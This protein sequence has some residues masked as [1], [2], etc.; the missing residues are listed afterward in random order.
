VIREDLGT[1]ILVEAAAG[2]GKTQSLVDRMVALIVAGR[3]TVDRLSAVTFTIR[4][5]AQLK[6]RFQNALERSLRVEREAGRKQALSA[7]LRGIDGCFVGTI[8]AFCAR[9]L[10]ERPVEAGVDPG[11]EEMDE[12]EDGVARAEAWA[13]FVESLYFGDDPRLARLLDLGIELEDLREGFGE[14]CENSDVVIRAGAPARAPDFSEALRAI[15]R[16]LERVEPSLPPEA[17]AGGWSSFQDGVRRARRLRDLMDPA[18]PADFAAVARVFRP[19]EVVNG[20]GPR[21]AELERLR[22]D[23]VKPALAAWAEHVYPTVLSLLLSAREDYERWRRREGRLNFQDLLLFARDLLRDRPDVRAAL[24]SRFTPILVDEFQDTDPIQAEI[25]FYLTGSDAEERD[26]R[27][28]SPEPGSLFVA[29]DPKQSIYRFR[30]ADIETYE[31]V[32]RRVEECGGR[33]VRL[34][35]NFRSSPAICNWVNGVFGRPEFFPSEPTSRQAS[36][37]PIEPTRG[38]TGPEPAILRLETNGARGMDAIADA[39]AERI[40][41][42]IAGSVGSEPRRPGDFL[43]LFRRRKYMNDYARALERRGIPYE[44]GGGDAFKESDDLAMLLP[45][46]QALAEP[47]DPV[48]LLATLRGPLFGIDDTALYRFAR[49]GGRFDFRLPPPAGTDPGIATALRLFR[50][51]S[52]LV[53]A[54]PPA[55]AIGR[56]LERL[57]APAL[58]ATRELGESRA[59]NLLKALAAARSLSA[60]GLDF[61]KVVAELDRLRS[62]RLIEQMS[63]EPGRSDAVRLLTLHGAKGLEGR[64][65]FLADPARSNFPRRNLLVDRSGPEPHGH[66]RVVRMFGEHG[67]EEIARPPGW[68]ELCKVEQAFEEA[69]KTRLLYVGATRAQDAL[70]VSVCRHKT[71]NPSGSWARLDPFLPADLAAAPRPAAVRSAPPA[72]TTAAELEAFRSERSERRHSAATPGYSVVSVTSLAHGAS[73]EREDTGRGMAWGRIVHRLLEAAMRGAGTDLRAYAGNLYTEEE[74]PRDDLDEALAL[75]EAVRLS[76]LW[77]RAL[78]SSRRLVEVPF[79]LPVAPEEVGLPERSPPTIL[80]G[81]IDLVFEEDGGWVLVDYKSD[82]VAGK[83]AALTAF[84]APQV[85]RYRRFWRRLTGRPTRAGLFF[86]ETREEAWLPDPGSGAATGSGA[87]SWRPAGLSHSR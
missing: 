36:Y 81:A 61:A 11:F 33:V 48:P 34:S 45:L 24:R 78:A 42:W 32:R 59:G 66:L 51:G 2:T 38:A 18:R 76:A 17:P 41:E 44:I 12:P 53:D 80:Q 26:W 22:A 35:A 65:V 83:L 74:R 47:D 77:R 67:E 86:V 9:L 84:Y 63:L 52:E 30:R 25:L 20:A 79:A 58:A 50:E 3:T 28:L 31:I 56:V 14:L 39:D 75:V 7:A 43:I 8:H 27:K 69:E 60:E 70:V 54:L 15:D 10:R 23:H 82:A 73:V 62:E 55:A 37:G 40:A 16:F 6:Q 68:D 46:L 4:A 64:V 29:G 72:G 71:G 57:G 85:E 19:G 13:R 87:E 1:T 49:A 5:A 21:R